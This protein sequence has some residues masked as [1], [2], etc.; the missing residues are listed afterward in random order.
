MKRG[1]KRAV[2]TSEAANEIKELYKSGKFSQRELASLFKCSQR[3]IWLCVNDKLSRYKDSSK[4]VQKPAASEPRSSSSKRKRFSSSSELKTGAVTS[5]VNTKAKADVKTVYVHKD[6]TFPNEWRRKNETYN[7]L[8]VSGSR[9]PK[10]AQKKAGD[11]YVDKHG[12][13]KRY[14]GIQFINICWRHRR[15]SYQCV[16]CN[17][18]GICEHRRNKWQCR[19]CKFGE[20]SASSKSNKR[21]RQNSSSDVPRSAQMRM[22]P[23]AAIASEDAATNPVSSPFQ[24]AN[25]FHQAAAYW[26][27][28]NAAMRTLTCSN[29]LVSNANP[30]LRMCDY[31]LPNAQVPP[32]SMFGLG[33]PNSPAEYIYQAATQ[34]ERSSDLQLRDHAGHANALNLFRFR[35]TVLPSTS[36][37]PFTPFNQ[38]NADYTQVTSADAHPSLS[39]FSEEKDT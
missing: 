25:L 39:A 9:D 14:S 12:K 27:G 2:L 32:Q 19:V 5:P 10:L 30:V 37:F 21:V 29:G 20:E 1:G 17:G 3:T 23:A 35:N 11:L 6:K 18:M 16:D 26:A 34:E 28:Y 15:R 24:S 33:H 7:I 4:S 38:H 22:S 36:G 8:S 13:F 31:M